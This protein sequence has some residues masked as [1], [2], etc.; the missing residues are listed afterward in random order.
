[1]IE[2]VIYCFTNNINGKKYIGQTV[3]EKERFKE[4]LTNNKQRIDKAIRKYGIFNF[5][6]TILERISGASNDVHRALDFLE[7]QYIEEFDTMIPNGYNVL[8]GGNSKVQYLV[9]RKNRLKFA[10]VYSYKYIIRLFKRAIYKIKHF[11]C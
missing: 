7:K 3:R 1:M 11:I 8:P 9:Y 2:G 4:H 6:Y 10:F 5:E